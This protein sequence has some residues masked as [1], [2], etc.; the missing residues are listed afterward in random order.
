MATLYLIRHPHTQPDPAIP[1]SQWDLSEAGEAQVEALLRAPFWAQ[2]AA[3]YT[4]PQRKTR[5]VGE[6][7]RAAYGLP[8]HEVA[9][10]DEAARDRWLEPAAFQA[11]QRAF[12]AAPDRAPVPGWEAA[13][14]ARMRFVAA[15]DE[16]FGRHTP[17]DS[18]AVVTHAT[19]LTLYLAYLRGAPARF[20]DWGAI[21]FA[22]V[23]ALDRV[24]L[25]P[26]TAFV[27]APYDGLSGS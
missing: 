10:L 19:V 16:I 1:A 7:V 26:L 11:A 17:D 15:L 14:P 20:A 27:A 12:F 25:R 18:I 21:G 24:A 22:E 13:N 8:V 3:V 9:G 23:V 4:S 2:V 5:R 6:A